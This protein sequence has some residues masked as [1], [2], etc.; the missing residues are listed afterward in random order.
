MT[1]IRGQIT[2]LRELQIGQRT[3]QDNKEIKDVIAKLFIEE[4]YISRC[5]GSISNSNE[6]VKRD[7]KNERS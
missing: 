7:S 4:G 2:P 3:L 6:E 5:Q 1:K